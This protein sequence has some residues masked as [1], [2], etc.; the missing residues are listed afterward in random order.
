M[1]IPQLHLFSYDGPSSWHKP[2][3]MEIPAVDPALPH[4][5]QLKHFIQVVRREVEPIVPPADAIRTL[6]TLKA[7]KQAAETGTSVDL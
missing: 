2:I 1:S 3:Q 7:I 4:T 6:Q 5:M